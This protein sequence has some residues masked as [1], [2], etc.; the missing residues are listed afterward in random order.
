MHHSDQRGPAPGAAPGAPAGRRRHRNSPRRQL[1]RPPAVCAAAGPS[2]RR[3]GAQSRAGEGHRAGPAPGRAPGIA[4]GAA[5]AAALRAA[6]APRRQL[7][8]RV[9]AAAELTSSHRHSGQTPRLLL[10]PGRRCCCGA[11][12]DVGARPRC[13]R[14]LPAGVGAVL[15]LGDALRFARSQGLN[16]RCAACAVVG[17]VCG[18]GGV[19][20][21][22]A[23]TAAPCPPAS[24]TL[25]GRTA[26]VARGQ[27]AKNLIAAR[28]SAPSPRPL[29]G[30]GR[31][32]ARPPRPRPAVRAWAAGLRRGMGA[33]AGWWGW[34]RRAGVCVCAGSSGGPGRVRRG[35]GA[36][37]GGGG[38]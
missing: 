10:P 20:P 25:C 2:C 30:G 1:T 12:G 19:D 29:R 4:P 33:P 26:P 13:L 38:A 17:T 34:R 18:R 28:C 37:G 3:R 9:S 15:S 36:P 5:R 27:A 21:G 31:C 23:R 16:A 6:P 8:A 24:G 7:C 14:A 32:A 35:S 22:R 11:G